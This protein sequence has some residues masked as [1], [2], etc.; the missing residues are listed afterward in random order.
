MTGFDEKE[1][2]ETILKECPILTNIRGTINVKGNNRVIYAYYCNRGVKDPDIEYDRKFNPH[3][4]TPD[5][6]L[7]EIYSVF[8]EK[9][10]DL[11]KELIKE[12]KI[13]EGQL[14]YKGPW[15]GD[16]RN[17]AGDARDCFHHEYN[18]CHSASNFQEHFNQICSN[19]GY[20]IKLIDFFG[21]GYALRLLREGKIEVNGASRSGEL[22]FIKRLAMNLNK[23]DPPLKCA[24]AAIDECYHIILE[25]YLSTAK[26]LV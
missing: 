25:N 8:G 11:R 6:T 26:I 1:V 5:S 10:E 14:L 7:C 18:F 12:A 4:T 20:K 9:H 19:L 16:W 23:E 2:L 3:P 22:P 24:L 17:P 13:E 15:I 21:Q